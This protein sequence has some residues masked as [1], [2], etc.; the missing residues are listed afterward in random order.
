MESVSDIPASQVVSTLE[1]VPE[2]GSFATPLNWTAFMGIAE[3]RPSGANLQVLDERYRSDKTV[4]ILPRLSC[5]L[6]FA[7]KPHAS[8]IVEM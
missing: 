4:M 3:P 1:P 5:R 8:Y 2:S 7:A 6:R